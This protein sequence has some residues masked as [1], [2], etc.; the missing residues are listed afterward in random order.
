MF[1]KPW[2]SLGEILG[3][4][5]CDDGEGVWSQSSPP[6]SDRVQVVGECETQL[7]SLLE[8]ALAVPVVED[9]GICTL[10]AESEVFQDVVAALQ[11]ELVAV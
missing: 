1:C 4:P 5:F 10:A 6:E 9:K 3:R 7:H 11:H 2:T 8:G